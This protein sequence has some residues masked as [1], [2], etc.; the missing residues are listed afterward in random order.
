[1]RLQTTQHVPHGW[2]KKCVPITRDIDATEGSV[3]FQTKAVE[4]LLS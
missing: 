3:A 2:R 1:M 4:C